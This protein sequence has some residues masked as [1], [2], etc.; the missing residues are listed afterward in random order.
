[1][2]QKGFYLDTPLVDWFFVTDYKNKT[3]QLIKK[4]VEVLAGNGKYVREDC[5]SRNILKGTIEKKESEL[6][7]TYFD[8]KALDGY[9]WSA[10]SFIKDKL[11]QIVTL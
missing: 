11:T 7:G 2:K 4:I 8:I 6:H 5:V 3:P 9:S 10:G 1:M